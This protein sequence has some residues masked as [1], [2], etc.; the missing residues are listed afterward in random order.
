MNTPS[1][2]EQSRPAPTIGDT[3]SSTWDVS[4]NAATQ[5]SFDLGVRLAGNSANVVSDLQ[6]RNTG[7]LTPISNLSYALPVRAL[8]PTVAALTASLNAANLSGGEAQARRRALDAMQLAQSLHSSDPLAAINQWLK[9]SKEV[10]SITSVDSS[11]WRLAAARLLEISQRKACGLSNNAS[12][13]VLG[14]ASQYNGFFFENFT[15][16]TKMPAP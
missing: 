9:V 13:D 6:R 3:Q 2:V 1:V 15:L 4:M 8:A 10:T 5:R 12:C 11:S 16:T 7:V 14:V